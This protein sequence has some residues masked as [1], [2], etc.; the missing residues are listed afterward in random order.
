MPGLLE[1]FGQGLQS[2]GAILSP[3]VHKSQTMER[4]N[5]LENV[6]RGLQIRK[7]QR[8]LQAD[9]AFT[10][11][12]GGLQGSALT[13]SASLEKKLFETVQKRPEV[14]DSPRY[15]SA[16]KMASQMQ[17]REAAQAARQQQLQLSQDELD[18]RIAADKRIASNEKESLQIRAAAEKRLEEYQTAGRRLQ[19]IAIR[20][21]LELRRDMAEWRREQTSGNAS[22]IPPGAEGKTGE[23]FLKAL[24][25]DLQSIVKKVADYDIDPRTLSTRG[26]HR[27]KILSLAAQYNPGYDDKDYAQIK[28]SLYDFSTGKQGQTTRSLNVAVEHLDTAKRFADALKNKDFPL[29]NRIANEISTQTGGAAPTTLEA[30]KEIVA[31]EVVKGVIGGP[32]ALA[33]RESAAK[34][35]RAASSPEQFAGIVSAWTELMGGQLKGLEKQ[36]EGSTRRKDFKEKYLTPRAR[37]AL[38]VSDHGATGGGGATVL[39]FDAQGNQIK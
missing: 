29:I 25:A 9:E 20:G 7:A 35:I 28:R 16:M 26:G 8:E 14:M 34:K 5:T 30:V 2:A 15:H 37:D 24:P 12:F 38:K 32:G 10:T 23:E 18:R 22:P 6:A 21:N 3:E 27:E 17:A 1:D 36:Y 11:E 4:Q 33:D 13:D 39:K 31:D 19:E